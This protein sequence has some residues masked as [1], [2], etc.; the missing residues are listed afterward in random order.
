MSKYIKLASL[1]NN[2]DR[3]GLYKL[4]DHLESLWLKIAADP[5]EVKLRPISMIN[6]YYEEI[7]RQKINDGFG[8]NS[9]RDSFKEWCRIH[10]Y[11]FDD[12]TRRPVLKYLFESQPWFK[13]L[14]AYTNKDRGFVMKPPKRDEPW[15]TINAPTDEEKKEL[16]IKNYL[17]TA[18]LISRQTNYKIPVSVILGIMAFESGWTSSNKS[19]TGNVFG[20]TGLDEEFKRNKART[21]YEV[22]AQLPLFLTGKKRYHDAQIFE[23][24]RRYKQQLKRNRNLTTQ[25]KEQMVQNYIQKLK[26]AGYNS[27]PLP[28]VKNVMNIIRQNNFTQYD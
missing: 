22:I 10:N 19:K 25:Q 28:Y 9:L 17:D 18:K 1:I 8:R 2:L 12:M 7:G 24:G 21:E 26:D 5:K 4:A 23:L 6:D 14:P 3:Y 27:E 13:N 20:L 15:R 16:F 11:N